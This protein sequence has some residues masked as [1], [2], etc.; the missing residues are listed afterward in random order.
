MPYKLFVI[1]GIADKNIFC[2]CIGKSLQTHDGAAAILRHWGWM[3]GICR[4][5]LGSLLHANRFLLQR[6]GIFAGGGRAYRNVGMEMT[7]AGDSVL[8]W[9]NI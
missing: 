4:R 6:R 8:T 1:Y 7:G 5:I 3:P 2:R 9:R